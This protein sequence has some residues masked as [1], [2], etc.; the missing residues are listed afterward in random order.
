MLLR[1]ETP[2]DYAAI[3]EINIRAFENRANEAMIIAALRL[4]PAF[5]PALSLV[6]EVDGQLVGHVLF[7]PCTLRLLGQEVLAVTLAPLAVLPEFQGRGIGAALTEAGHDVTRRKGYA[8]SFLLGH[9]SYYPRLG[10]QTRAYGVSTVKAAFPDAPATRLESRPP[11]ADDLPALEIL[12]EREEAAVDFASFPGEE[13]FD[14]I[15]PNP[16]MES[17]VWLRGGAVIGYTRGLRAEPLKPRCFFALDEFAALD[18]ARALAHKAGG[19]EVELPLHPASRSAAAFGAPQ[20][21]AWEAAMV[22]PFTPSPFTEYYAQVQAG[23]R[24]PGR[25]IW[26]TA[27]DFD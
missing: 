10:Y 7:T 17:L 4:R 24:P 15:S 20:V 26:G 14:W 23:S 9:P 16:A 8:L 27:F 5:D 12:W 11:T 13:L 3:T 19:G 6:A 1:P 2:S 18:V 22:C 21:K 25:V